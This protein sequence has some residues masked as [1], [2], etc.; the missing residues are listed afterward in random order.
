MVRIRLAAWI[1]TQGLAVASASA[2]PFAMNATT[3]QVQDVA[4]TGL[5]KAILEFDFGTNAAPQAYLFGYQ[6]NPSAS[7]TGRDVLSD[8]QAN[9]S[10]LSFTDTFFPSFGEYLLNTL[11]YQNNHPADDYPNAFWLYFLGNDAQTWSDAG[12]GYDQTPV[13][14]NGFF[15]W[16][17]QHDDPNFGRSFSLPPLDPSHFPSAIVNGAATVP[18]PATLVA[19]SL[20]MI[21]FSLRRR[22]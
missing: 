20:A 10:G 19:A 7:P 14:N 3:Y 18:E 15:A 6:W 2:M 5:D 4:G 8:L 12:T 1:V 11:W 21:S 13:T 17:L 22:R 16:A 9:A